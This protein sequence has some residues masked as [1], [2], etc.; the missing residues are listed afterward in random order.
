M[1]FDQVNWYK[2]A[3]W[4]ITLAMVFCVYKSFGDLSQI[5]GIRSPL[6]NIMLG[7]A[8]SV[9]VCKFLLAAILLSIDGFMHLSK[10]IQYVYSNF[11]KSD[12]I[13]FNASRRKSL[14]WIASIGAAIPFFSLVYAFTKGKYQYTVKKLIVKIPNLPDQFSGYKLVQISDIHAGS[15]DSLE[16]VQKGINMINAIDPD[17]VV[18]T[19]DLVNSNKD[20][21][22]PFIG[23][24]KQIQA[25]DGKFSIT[26]N[27][28]YY[29]MPKTNV[30]D[31]QAYWKSFVEKHEQM[32]FKLLSNAHHHIQRGTSK[33]ALI[34]VD[35][36]GKG[37]FPKKGDLEKAVQGI[38]AATPK[39]LLSHDPT[40]WEAFVMD[41]VHDIALTLSGHTHGMQFGISALGIQ[42]SP[43]KWRYKRWSGIYQENNR[44]LYVNR[45]FG[46]LGFPGRVGMLPEI[47]AIELQPA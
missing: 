2:Y 28:D 23:V 13:T 5:Q 29:G 19:G 9:I 30:S 31:R 7:F 24:F 15:F 20:E 6:S 25:R 37:P 16:Q 36:W 40:H 22:D 38:E 17:L 27:H 47:T 41:G 42:W 1:L 46:F 45:G 43:I 33:L 11:A 12:H 35:N 34:G 21:I 4:L 32:G 10:G 14:T 18:F 26:G 3:Y 8:F 39:V 44:Q